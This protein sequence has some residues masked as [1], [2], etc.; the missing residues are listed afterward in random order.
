MPVREPWWAPQGDNDP[1]PTTS[2]TPGVRR[3]IPA[4]SLISC[5]IT[6]TLTCGFIF[7]GY[8]ERFMSEGD[9][10]ILATGEGIIAGCG[11]IFSTYEKDQKGM[12][13]AG[14]VDFTKVAQNRN[15]DPI[16]PIVVKRIIP[17]YGYMTDTPPS[18]T[19]NFYSLNDT[20]PPLSATLRAMY[21]GRTII[22]YTPQITSIDLNSLKEYA[23]NTPNTMVIPWINDTI[24]LR[25]SKNSINMPRNRSFAFSTWGVTQS[26]DDWKPGV[27]EH[28]TTTARTVQ[29]QHPTPKQPPT[30]T[31][32][33]E[34]RLPAFQ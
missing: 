10:N 9:G 24:G 31:P 26:C 21:D 27:A 6:A 32:N 16:T 20:P 3:F 13:Q 18:D 23:D 8:G 33:S 17:A 2:A 1:T 15:G 11:P 34:G 12:A 4:I 7:A 25:G 14:V 29:Q 22:W 19:V 5:L 28:F 30:V